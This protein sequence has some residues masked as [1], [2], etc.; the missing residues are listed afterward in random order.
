RG[1]SLPIINNVSSDIYESVN[2]INEVE[3]DQHESFELETGIDNEHLVLCN[4]R[5][6]YELRPNELSHVCLYEFNSDYRKAKITVSDKALFASDSTPRSVPRRGRPP[7]D[8]WLFQTQHPQYSSHIIIRRSFRVVPVLIGPSIPRAEREDTEERY[9]RAI[10]TLFYPWRSVLD[11]YDIHEL[12]SNVLKVRESAFT[13]RSDKVINNIQLL[14][15]CKRDRDQDLFQLVNQPLPSKTIKYTTQYNDANVDDAEEILALLDETTDVHLNLLNKNSIECC[16]A[17]ER[18]KREYLKSILRN[19]IL[20]ERFSHI[21]N[22]NNPFSDLILSNCIIQTTGGTESNVLAYAANRQ[23]IEHIRIWQYNLKIQKEQM[24]RML[25]YGSKEQTSEGDMIIDKQFSDPSCADVFDDHTIDCT[26]SV[27]N[28]PQLTTNVSSMNFVKTYNLNYEQA[29]IFESIMC[30]IQSTILYQINKDVKHTKPE[31]LLMYIGG[32]G[33]CGKSRVTEAISAF[34]AYHNRTHTIRCLAPSSAAAVGID[35]LTIQSMLHEGR[36]KTYDNHTLTQTDLSTI[37]TE[38]RNIDYC[39]IDEISMVGCYML[40]RLHR[41]T[42]IAKHTE[43]TIPFGGIN[44]IFLGDFVQYPPVLDRPLYSNI[45]SPTDTL[46][47]TMNT[48]NLTRRRL[49]ITERDIQCK[50]GRALWLQ[51]N[52]V[53]FLTQQMR[54]KDPLFTAMQARLRSGQCRDDDYNMLCKRIVSSDND[55]KSLGQSPWNL[56]PM[57]V[58]RNEVRTNINNYC[59]F[60]ES[61]KHNQLPTVV[62]AN[63]RV[64]NHDIDNTDLRH[65]LLSLPDNKTDGL[66]GYLPIVMNMPVLITHNIATELH[67]SNGSIGRLVRLV[68]DNDNE[69]LHNNSDIRNPNFPINTKYIQTPLYALVELPQSKLSSPLIDLQPTMIP[70]LPEQKTIKIDLKSFITPTQK[71]LLNNKTSITICRTQLPIVPAYAMT[72]HKCQGKTLTSGIIDLVPPPY[73]KSDLANVYVPV[74]RFTS[75]D[76]MAILRPFPQSIL[77]QKPHP[78]MIIELERLNKLCNSNE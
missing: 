42:T 76:T 56:A 70:I 26:M 57:L 51:V 52:K 59:V 28:D 24:R 11:I 30:H 62:V 72:T 60:D 41:I 34:M 1:N 21:N 27:I 55:V 74:S 58:F 33:G 71:R 31:Q 8:R 9:A 32:A 77:N 36:N 17:R 14:H 10:L 4:K 61:I 15:D 48:I 18:M 68:Y 46:A 67:I 73:A 12:W 50:V 3:D 63:D 2:E 16:G 47:N 23:D 64:R 66:P 19:I 5:I 40:A 20:S 38:W 37:E 75:A 65:F 39:L 7:N 54:N 44:M 25:L 29:K 35:G 43:S 6:D 49:N 45:L 22:N 78:D 53:F 13:A 69:N